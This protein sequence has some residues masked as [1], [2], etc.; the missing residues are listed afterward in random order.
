MRKFKALRL[1]GGLALL[2]LAEV[3][4]LGGIALISARPAE[5]QF[6]EPRYQRPRGGGFFDSLFGG[7]GRQRYDD[8][9]IY[10]EAPPAPV[11]N[12]R[13]PPPRKD[14][15]ADQVEPT[16]SV[17]VFGD[18]MAD[19]LAYGLEDAFADAPEVSIVRKAKPYSGLL[20]Y[21]AKTDQDWWHVARDTL[22]NDKANYVVMMLGVGDRQ[23]LRER[24]VAKEAEQ[25]AKDQA[26]KE[27]ANAAPQDQQ[28]L[29]QAKK[30]T[31]DEG[32]IV[33]PE[34]KA[35]A[36]R[37]TAAG[38]VIEFRSEPWEKVYTRRIDDTV[39]ALKSKGVPVF[40]VGLP[41]IRGAKSTADTGYL[42]D[43]YRA[44]AEKAG[45]VYVDVWDGFVDEEG[46]YTTTGPDYEGQVRRLRA[47]DGVYFTRYGSRKLAHYVEREIRR[48]MANRGPIALPM[49]PVAPLPNDGKPAA[50]P[51]AGPVVP[52]TT[53]TGN[54]DEL[55]GGA[56][57]ARADASATAVLVKGDA[58]APAPGRADDF[59]WPPG[60]ERPKV[61]PPVAAPVQPAVPKAA[62]VT[63][64]A[65]TP[66]PAAL[67]QAP[68]AIAAPE[69]EVK[70]AAPKPV[71]VKPAAVEPKPAAQ[72]RAVERPRPPVADNRPRQPQQQQAI[73]PRAPRPPQGIAQQPP[74]RRDDGGLFGI[75]R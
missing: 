13:A 19:W 10:R 44:R 73:D 43:L 38:G 71:D 30:E 68:A 45:A 23:N 37:R 70:P 21:D 16:T 66:A 2:G 20:R 9:E 41:P 69:P 34:P 15:K 35:P 53:I 14:T 1:L 65:A 59:I 5:A 25:Q 12:S 18:S 32:G 49:G 75:F 17:I 7:G 6:F 50:R 36:A 22:A 8:R 64:P 52:L 60:S 63:P 51:L 55:A 74:R 62:A 72:P 54:N 27:Q 28:K 58:L 42:N 39:A 11:D 3:A 48:Y 57:N 47:G 56:A 46:K 29:D 67:P 33:A 26:N 31:D 24:D 40:W 61:E 4:A